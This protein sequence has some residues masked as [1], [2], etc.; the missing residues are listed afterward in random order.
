MKVLVIDPKIAG[1][2]G[3]MLIAALVDLTGSDEPLVPIA[4]AIR[5]LSCCDHFSFQVNDVDAGGI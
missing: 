5:G 2:S 1:I 3:D 4:D